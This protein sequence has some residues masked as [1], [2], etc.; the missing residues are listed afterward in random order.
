MEQFKKQFLV[1]VTIA[2]PSNARAKQLSYVVTFSTAAEGYG[3]KTYMNIQGEGDSEYEESLDLR[4]NA[5]YFPN[6]NREITY[7][8]HWA[9]NNW[10]GKNKAWKLMELKIKE[11]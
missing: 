9:S 2:N 5:G 6:A 4:Y 3:N 10:S 1:S 7:I 11:I 8:A